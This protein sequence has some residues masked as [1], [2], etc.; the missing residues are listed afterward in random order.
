MSTKVRIKKDKVIEALSAKL[1][2]KQDYPE[3][4]KKAY[5]QYEKELEAFKKRVLA[6]K[7]AK[8]DEIDFREWRGTTDLILT[9][10]VELPKG[11]KK[12]EQPESVNEWRLKEEISEIQQAIRMLELCEDDEV[13]STLIKSFS[14]Y[15]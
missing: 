1:K 14:Q 13:T 11:L 6:L 9:F 5:A 10:K 4:Y 7:K 12:P 15:L 2:E 8:P 3:V